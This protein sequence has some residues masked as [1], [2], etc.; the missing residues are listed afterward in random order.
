MEAERRG[1]AGKDTTRARLVD[2]AVDAF[3]ASGYEAVAVREI[4]RRAN[5]NR[6]LVAYHFGSKEE[7]WREAV[8]WLMAPL[9]DG[10]EHYQDALRSVSGSDRPRLVIKVVVRLFVRHLALF[11]ILILAGDRPE[12][13]AW[14]VDQHMRPLVEFFRSAAGPWTDT[15]TEPDE[16]LYMTTGAS[17]MVALVLS[18]PSVFG[19]LLNVDLSTDTSRDEFVDSVTD[20]FIRQLAAAE[21]ARS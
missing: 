8:A 19:V 3:A 2:A 20:L 7:L 5:V 15:A 18:M 4:E 12:L 1:S 9:R 10:L 16:I 17:A 14:F 21:E 11:R 13:T 6:G